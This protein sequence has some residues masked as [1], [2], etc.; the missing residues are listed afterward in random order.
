MIT[1]DYWQA[2]SIQYRQDIEQ[3]GESVGTLSQATKCPTYFQF[4][5]ILKT[6]HKTDVLVY[7]QSELLS[8]T[9]AMLTGKTSSEQNSRLL[10]PWR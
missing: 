10:S 4:L 3:E 7:F 5:Q 8:R 6:I 2:A 9:T 1:S